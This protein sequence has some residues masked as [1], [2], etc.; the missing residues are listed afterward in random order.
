MTD[1]HTMDGALGAL[2]A[3]VCARRM[4]EPSHP[5]ARAALERAAK[6]LIAAAEGSGTIDL[7]LIEGRVVGPDGTL[8]ASKAIHAAVFAPL[9]AAGVRS[10]RLARGLSFA[11]CEALAAVLAGQRAAVDPIGPGLLLG[12]GEVV[13]GASAPIAPAEGNAL[14]LVDDVREAVAGEDAGPHVN[15]ARLENVAAGVCAAVLNARGTML[16]MASLKSY[17]EYSYVH[18]V[19]VALLTAALGE[20]CGL[21]PSAMHDLTL[22]AMLHDA[23][24]RVLPAAILN[25]RAPLDERERSIMQRHPVDGAR[26]LIGQKGMPSLAAIVAFEHHMHLDGSGYPERPKGWRPH[27]CAQI[28]QQADVYD[29]LRTHRPYR[30]AMTADEAAG[31]LRQGAGTRYD[32]DLV[33]LFITG[34]VSRSRRTDAGTTPAA[35]KAA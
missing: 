21:A 34:V 5:A 28:V 9:E 10:L 23:G 31:I 14:V 6:A 18:T 16:E 33:E 32:A 30:A 4:Y 22:S 25:K 26:L 3:A 13:T 29:A 8:P 2:A 17:D 1:Q 35:A 12:R 20:A 7:H 15:V 19:N 11:E 24:K 27:F